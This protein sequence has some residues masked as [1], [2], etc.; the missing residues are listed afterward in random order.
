MV[1]VKSVRSELSF[2]Q[3]KGHKDQWGTSACEDKKLG[4]IR[5]YIDGSGW[6]GSGDPSGADETFYSGGKAEEDAI[7]MGS[8]AGAASG[9]GTKP[10]LL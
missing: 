2:H 9:S 5:D 3:V 10:P 1:S 6:G 7:S 4:N 8:P